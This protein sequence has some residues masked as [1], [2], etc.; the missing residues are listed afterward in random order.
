VSFLPVRVQQ[1]G[2]SQARE[3]SAEGGQIEVVLNNGRRVRV[4]GPV[5]STAL[6][7]VLSAA[8]GGHTC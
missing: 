7:L 3:V 2:S 1:A 6:A 5:D 4:V 8:E